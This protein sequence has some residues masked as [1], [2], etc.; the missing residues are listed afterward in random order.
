MWRTNLLLFIGSSSMHCVVWE[1][2]NPASMLCKNWSCS[3]FP[4]NCT[5]LDW[6][7]ALALGL[8]L[9]HSARNQSACGRRNA[10]T[11]VAFWGV[12]F[13]PREQLRGHQ[14]MGFVVLRA[15]KKCVHRKPEM[16]QSAPPSNAWPFGKRSGIV[17]TPRIV[18]T[19]QTLVVASPQ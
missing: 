12:G 11:C 19:S 4:R 15:L 8:A 3:P 14:A 10:P 17:S 16:R 2:C 6:A 7:Q 18:C 9:L 13:A 1:V 5:T